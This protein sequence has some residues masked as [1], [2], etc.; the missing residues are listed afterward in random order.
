MRLKILALAALT[1][2]TATPAF[3][4]DETAPPPAFTVNGTATVT[5]DY[6]FRGISQT[7]K[8]GAIQGS[9]TVT[10]ESG[11]Y[12]SVWASSVDNYVTAAGD[13][14]NGTSAGQASVEM[15][16]IGGF[17]KTFGGTT[18]DIGALYYVYPKTKLAGDPTS[19]DFIE[20]YFDISHT[21][22]VLT[23]KATVNYAP[24]QKALS[25]N[26][27]GPSHDNVYLAGDF[28]A[29]IPK[30][31]I[32]LSAHIAHSF[33]PSWLT[34]GNGYTDWNLGAS[35]TWKALTFTAQYVDTDGDFITPSGKNA[36]KAGFVGSVTAS[37]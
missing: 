12:A 17:K 14:V 32:S 15:D 36:S 21:F 7:D 4:Q 22:G 27:I 23:A 33:G 34:I 6:R 9:I 16:L 35:Y 3:A 24:K 37:F 2:G 30:T 25:L 10:H 26:Q 8:N 18:F 11:L 1:L 29:G 13:Y 5:S 31:P 20:P 19:S 28:S